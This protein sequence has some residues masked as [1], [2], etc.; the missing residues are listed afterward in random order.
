MYLNNIWVSYYVNILHK[1]PTMWRPKKKIPLHE[2]IKEARLEKN[3]W[4]D[5]MSKKADV[6]YVT[7]GK[8]ESGVTDNLVRIARALWKSVDELTQ[9]MYLEDK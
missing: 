6:S 7:Y 8:I 9:D 4:L 5:E 2:R 3:F 1:I